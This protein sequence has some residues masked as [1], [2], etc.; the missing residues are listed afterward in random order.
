MSLDLFNLPVPNI[1]RI[2][3]DGLVHARDLLGFLFV[4][5]FTPEAIALEIVIHRERRHDFLRWLRIVEEMLRRV[6][7]LEASAIATSFPPPTPARLLTAR[8]RKPA[9]VFNREDSTTWRLSLRMT[10]PAGRQ[11]H[12]KHKPSRRQ[13]RIVV[14]SR[15]LALRVQAILRALEDPHPYIQRLALRLRKGLD[16]F[17]HLANFKP[18]FHGRATPTLRALAT[19]CA[20]RFADTS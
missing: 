3:A 11:H 10:P 1:G 7:F 5:S 4:R 12:R 17:R 19:E 14:P 8:T 9:P 13:P 18:S 6:L 2:A 20:P 16:R 15:P